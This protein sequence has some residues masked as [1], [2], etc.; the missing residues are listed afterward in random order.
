MPNFGVVVYKNKQYIFMTSYGLSVKCGIDFC[1]I[2]YLAPKIWREISHCALQLG[3][4]DVKTK[5]KK[6]YD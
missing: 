2:F 3:A 4:S 1:Y 6:N 5:N